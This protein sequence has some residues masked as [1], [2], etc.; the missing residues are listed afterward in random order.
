[1]VLTGNKETGDLPER[2]R[3][4]FGDRIAIGKDCDIS[5][6]VLIEMEGHASLYLGDRVS[7]LR[8]TSIYVCSGATVIIEDDV[9]IGENVFLSAMV[10][11]R[12]GKGC[13]ISN[14]VDIHDHNHRDRSFEYV[15]SDGLTSYASGFEGAP[16]V[17]ESGVII[18]N[19]VSITAG[20]YIG[21]N[22]KVG[23]NSVV[24]RSLPANT[25]AIGSPAKPVRVFDG[26][27]NSGEP[28]RKLHLSFF[29]ASIMEH[30]EASASKLHDQ[31]DLP[32]VKSLVEVEEWV[33]RGFPYRVVLCLQVGWPDETIVL[34]NRATGGATS[35]DVLQCVK[36]AIANL[37]N[38]YDIA[39][40]GCGINDVWRKFQGR[41]DE[42][43][44]LLE[45]EANCTRAL[46]LLVGSARFVVCLSE[47]PFGLPNSEDMNTSLGEYNAILRS[48][49]AKAGADYLDIW[50][51]FVR[52]AR[53]FDAGRE[54][55]VGAPSLW[56]DGVHL[57]DLGDALVAD[58]ILEHLKLKD[59][60]QKL[61]KYE[62]FERHRA[63]EYYAPLLA[64][65]ARS[66]LRTG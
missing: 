40:F 1:M 16:I 51:P 30:F 24:S 19:K 21:Q 53:A 2:L 32:A 43:V 9:D 64:R 48:A 50:T 37:D 52:T 55:G 11:I 3:R 36:T 60:M 28:R 34:H 33:N 8:G 31:A 10:G 45:F 41:F 4:Q 18:S 57:T 17:I 56:K 54:G 63:L 44:G 42:A 46:H 26:P 23:A 59:V 62:R 25:L 14:M 20:V 6:D 27:L 35:R 12:I 13:G 61:Q 22:T 39:F 49:A 47:T 65:Y 38:R 15:S 58:C 7:V 29:G 5:T 66:D